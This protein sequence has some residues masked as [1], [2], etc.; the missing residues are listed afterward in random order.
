MRDALHKFRTGR[1]PLARMIGAA[2]FDGSAPCSDERLVEAYK[3]EA[4][5][6]VP[7]SVREMPG[8]R[9]ILQGFAAAGTRMAI[10]SNGW[11]ELQRAK[12][13]A[14]SFPGPVITSSDVAAWKPQPL[15]FARAMTWLQFS[16]PRTVYVGDQPEVDVA[17]A[18]A[19]G[20]L[21]VWAGLETKRYPP[22]VQR[23]DATIRT[24]SEL[25]AVVAALS[26]RTPAL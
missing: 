1:I 20:M 23:P 9:A 6:L 24:L 4:L 11:P 25:P 3:S 22:D 2:L 7:S 17:G 18:K 21:A 12:A 5:S 13:A 14:L 16:P 19:A 26:A 8:A 15:A 10:F